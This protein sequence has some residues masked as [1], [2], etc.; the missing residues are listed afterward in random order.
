LGI[1]R[2]P[3][4]AQEIATRDLDP[5]SRAPV[6]PQARLAVIR[7]AV[8]ATVHRAARMD[9]VV[10]RSPADPGRPAC[11]HRFYG[12]FTN[13]AYTAP[14]L[15]GTIR[16]EEIERA[17]AEHTRSWDDRLRERLVKQHRGARGRALAERYAELFTP[18]YKASTEVSAAVDDIR[19]IEALTG[20]GSIEIELADAL[21]AD[22]DRFTLLK[23][24]LAGEGIVLSDF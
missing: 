6:D 1:V 3:E 23:L 22:A 5:A 9:V 11:E 10:V 20:P 24:Y 17:I 13:K 21:G 16:V 12:L 19:H 18:E 14:P 4:R 7:S 15:A 2:I 8:E